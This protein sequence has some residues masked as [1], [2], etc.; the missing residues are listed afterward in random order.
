MNEVMEH[1][2]I[3]KEI[4]KA[5]EILD[6]PSKFL[7]KLNNLEDFKK[8]DFG[9]L[10]RLID[11]EQEPKYHPE[12]N[13]WN[14]LCMVVDAASIAKPLVNNKREFMWGALLHDIGKLT[15]TVK[16]K[17]RWTSYNHDEVGCDMAKEILLKETC[18]EEFTQAVATLV[19]FHMHHIYI[20]KNLPFGNIEKLIETN[21]V[22]DIVMLFLCDKLGRGG[23]NNEDK[24]RVFEEVLSIL[25]IIEKKSSFKYDDVR[26]NVEKFELSLK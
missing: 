5:L 19:K 2:N 11:I 20:L 9:V 15:T 3:F 21:N 17:G 10:G 6:K 26:R 4:D 16:R 14:H 12:G 18:D 25:D 1:I 13:V 23:Q 22:N 8:S 7:N 24:K